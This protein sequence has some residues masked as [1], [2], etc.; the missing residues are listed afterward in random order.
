MTTH[1]IGTISNH[2]RLDPRARP[3]E[4]QLGVI[5][6]ERDK[7]AVFEHSPR[8][9]L[10]PCPRSARFFDLRGGTANSLWRTYALNVSGALG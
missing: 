9:D 8:A 1:L 7:D 5:E 2:D 4:S 3:L 10:D 6:L